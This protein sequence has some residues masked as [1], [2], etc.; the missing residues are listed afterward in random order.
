V[1]ANIAAFFRS[2][3]RIGTPAPACRRGQASRGDFM[4]R[5]G[6]A[7]R[8]TLQNIENIIK[9]EEEDEKRVSATER[10]TS[11]AAHLTQQIGEL[12]KGLITR[13]QKA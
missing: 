1:Q 13:H 7:Q 3:Y 4:M 5:P 12:T 9:L 10:A 6:P 8:S 2:R 11:S